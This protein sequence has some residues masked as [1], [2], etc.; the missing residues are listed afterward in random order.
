[1]ANKK[2]VLGSTG[3]PGS[4]K[5]IIM[6]VAK[7][8]GYDTVIMGDIVREEAQK[9]GLE[10]NPQ[11][12]GRIMLELRL[13]GGKGV[14]AKRC[15]PRIEKAKNPKVVVDGIRSLEEAE[16]F[17]KYFPSFTLVAI[18]SSPETR[19][20]RLFNRRRS[21]DADEWAVFHERDMRELGVG[22]GNAMAI[23]E[24]MI[25]NEGSLEVVRRKVKE[26]LRKVEEKWS[27]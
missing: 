20:Q 12:I 14:V 26:V 5:S 18:H 24:Y 6:R 22:V 3:M 15:I 21:D 1:M 7:D 9:R 13:I 11:N 4:G 16:E 19:F 10:P 8:S 2:L 25:V 23:A 27:R 17:N